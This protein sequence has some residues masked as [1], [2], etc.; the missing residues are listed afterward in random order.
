MRQGVGTD[1]ERGI[2]QPFLRGVLVGSDQPAQELVRAQRDV[3]GV[4][5]VVERVLAV[6]GCDAARVFAQIGTGLVHHG[7]VRLVTA[8]FGRF[9]VE[10]WQRHDFGNIVHG[11]R[12]QRNFGA[13]VDQRAARRC[14]AAAGDDACQMEQQNVDIPI[15]QSRVLFIEFGIVI[16]SSR[17]SWRIRQR[18]GRIGG[19]RRG[20]T[21]PIG[22]VVHVDDVVRYLDVLR[23]LGGTAL[24][25]GVQPERLELTLA[26]RNDQLVAR[27]QPMALSCGNQKIRSFLRNLDATAF[28][29]AFHPACRVHGITEELEARFFT[30]QNTSCDGAR[31][32]SNAQGQI[33]RSRPQQRFKFL[34]EFLHA[35]QRLVR[36]PAHVDGV[37]RI[38]VRQTR[39]GHVTIADRFDLEDF[40][41][42]SDHVEA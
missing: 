7:H 12:Q 11:G 9:G 38:W 15:D 5:E 18:R 1:A 33:A 26:L 24:L 8:E 14:S 20:C 10:G 25:R 4:L 36:K 6:H 30:A 19:S 2:M 35:Q 40:Q 37:I 31:M 22:R 16:S 39:H 42:G 13:V 34:D 23:G 27:L 3:R 21:T 41:L 28:T 29:C 32:Q 17:R